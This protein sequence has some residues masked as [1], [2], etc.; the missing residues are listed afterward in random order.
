MANKVTLKE[1][2]TIAGVSTSAAW[3]AL[4]GKKTTIVL[5]E[6]TK[7]KIIELAKEMDYQPNLTARGLVK[8]QS[9]LISFLCRESFNADATELLM[10]MQDILLEVGYSVLVYAH[11]D[12]VEDELVNLKNSAAR[13]AQAVIV[14]PAL[15]PNGD[16]NS[17]VFQDIFKEGTPVVQ[18]F[19][20]VIPEVPAV[21]AGSYDAGQF[22]VEYLLDRGHRQI[23]YFT[24]DNYTEEDFFSEASERHRGYKDAMDKAGLETKIYAVGEFLPLKI[25]GNKVAQAIVNDSY[26]PTAVVCYSD[27]LA[28]ALRSGLAKK[29]VR[30]PEDVSLIGYGGL[31]VMVEGLDQ[32]FA[33][34]LKPL[35]QIGQ[36]AARMCLKKIKGQSINDKT[37]ECEFR[38]G[39]SVSNR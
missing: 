7:K 32:H 6:D 12:T 21:F 20:R 34:F 11:G 17:Q 31:E 4:S 30:I 28:M 5:N 10:G 39:S 18:L 33:T 26:C 25:I 29:G 27:S 24:Y 37:C 2:A 8:K 22:S 15:E 38:P 35:R 23:A 16:C 36:E 1:I 19:N 14:T 13:Q 3:A 9:Y